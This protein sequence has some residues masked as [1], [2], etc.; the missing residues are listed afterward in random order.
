MAIQSISK[1]SS[2]VVGILF[3]SLTAFSQLKQYSFEQTD[4]LQKTERR[5]VVVFIHTDWCSYCQAMKN[6][7]FEDQK[8]IESLNKN[9]WFISLNAEEQKDIRFNG[10]IFK[11][12]PT[13]NNVGIHEL[14]EE[15]GTIGD[16]IAYPVLCI[17]SP[18]CEIIFQYNQ[19]LA[20]D[21][22]QRI[23][24]IIPGKKIK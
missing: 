14:A 9:Y 20:P 18:D 8:I 21:D 3:S 23:L 1:L 10:H 15:L 13:G 19:Y 5:N 12:R 4:S 16:K 7:T 17:L 11:Y 24:G 2:L 6:I 22:L